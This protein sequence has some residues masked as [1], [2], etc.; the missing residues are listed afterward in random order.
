MFDDPVLWSH[1]KRFV[2]L[3]SQWKLPTMYGYREFVDDGGLISLG[4]DRIDH[5]RR[6]AI[7][8]DR[9]LKGA[10]PGSLPIEQPVKFQL[11]INAKS[12]KSLG[13][14]LP[15]AMLLAADEVIQ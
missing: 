5:Y 11:V 10:H 8:V 9:I 13:V 15:Q 4:P 12:A 2:E 6:T 14:A 3:A 1:R 7:Y